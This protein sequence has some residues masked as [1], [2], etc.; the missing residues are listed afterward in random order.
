LPGAVLAS[1]IG[2]LLGYYAG[3]VF[4]GT[5]AQ[6]V[7]TFFGSLAFILAAGII[8]PRHRA[9]VAIIIASLVSVLA[10]T[11]FA[12]SESTSL[13]P[14]VNMPAALK[15]LI[16]VAQILGGIYA[17]FWLQQMLASRL[18]VLLRKMRQLVLSVG[19]LGLLLMIVGLV[20][21][22]VNHHWL[23]F[24]VGLGVL[25]LAFLTW[26]FQKINLLLSTSR[27]VRH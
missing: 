3:G 11:E 24:G 4:G 21:V 16:P 2:G 8:A 13:E 27:A 22:L 10:V 12:L 26:L 20:N 14:Y 17:V 15:V 7:A 18:E 23:V 1:L 9:V 5:A 25:G 6:T 19:A